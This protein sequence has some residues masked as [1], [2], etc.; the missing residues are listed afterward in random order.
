MRNKIK[1]LLAQKGASAVIS[2]ISNSVQ[3]LKNA[4]Y[5]KS[6]IRETINEWF[7]GLDG[8]VDSY[9]SNNI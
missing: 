3:D 4:K 7:F 6:E 1:Q 8:A 2:A 9:I 5:T